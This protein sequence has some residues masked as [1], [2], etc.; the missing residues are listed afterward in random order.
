MNV[1][2]VVQ[3][4]SSPN[5]YGH[6]K[7][8][9]DTAT[10]FD[11][12]FQIGKTTSGRTSFGR[13][14][15]SQS[16]DRLI[17]ATTCL[18]G[19]PVEVQVLDGSVFSGIFHATNAEDFG[20][21]LKMAHTTNDGSWGQKSNSDSHTKPPSRTLII[22]AKDLVQV[23]AKDVPVTRDGFT[24]ELQHENQ[25]ELMT[26]SYISQSRYVEVG[27]ELEHW[28]PDEND[29]GCPELENIFDGPWNRGWDQ[30]E[31]NETLFG[32]KSTFS[33]ELYTTKLERGPQMRELER[34][35][36]RIAREIEGEDTLDFHL[37]EERGI[38]LDGYLEMDEETRFSSV[39][40]GADDSGYDEI[41]DILL[42]SRNNET[43]GGVSGSLTGETCVD[44]STGNA[45]DGTQLS[46][47]SS[48]L[49]EVEYSLTATSR[50]AYHSGSEDQ[51][52]QMLAEQLPKNWFD[53]SQLIGHADTSYP[54]EDEEKQ[55]SCIKI[56]II[57]S[58]D[59]HSFLRQKKESCYK[60]GLSPNATAFDPP[61][62]SSKG[63]EKVSSS[64]ELSEGAA[65]PVT[66]GTKSSLAR[67][68]SSASST[69]DRGGATSTSAG[70]GLS[71][72]S[73]VCSLS[74]E[75]STLNPH[76]KEFKLNPN[77]KSF[78]PSHTPLRPSSPVADGPFYYPAN[79]TAPTHMHAVPVGVGIG[80]S[81]AAQQPVIY[82]PQAASMPQPFYH[83][84]GP[85]Y[86]QQI[87]MGQPR[88]VLYMPTYPPGK[89]RMEAGY[90][91]RTVEEVFRDFKGRRAGLIKALTTD[92]EEF[93]QQC[94]PEKDNLC[95]YGFPSEQWEV[96]LPAE[97][98]PPEL[99]EP[100][101][102]IN[103]ARDGMQEKDWLSLVAVHSDA[104]LLAVA[105]YFGARFGFDKADRKRLF[106]MI[107]DLPT[108]FEV[109]TGAA[110]KQQKEKSS[111]SNHSSNKL[112]SN[113][114][115]RTSE[116]QGKLLKSQP[117][118]EEEGL[119]EEEEE[120]EH[121]ETLCGACGENYA[122]DEFWICCDICEKWFHGKCVKIT[123]ARAEHIKQY[124]CPSCSS[125]KRPRP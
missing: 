55:K 84:N 72:S 97:E 96:N 39:Y 101:L 80:P 30:F 125:N 5:G 105:F 116:T 24:N 42:D 107:N 62:A 89:K 1:Q 85:Q 46:S 50:G 69:S 12:K 92:V 21:V 115:T 43:F 27:R 82:N 68:S 58:A 83:P 3:P 81:I 95:L 60:V 87:I 124:K 90:N 40:R 61:H 66:Q 118:D 100:A 113:S 4:R 93:F 102:G 120:D 29:P 114:K 38:Q 15:E 67:P 49:G 71:P 13:V 108:V 73:S 99:P 37:A 117:K 94:D 109:V 34:E 119:D 8:E 70:R 53:D 54:K 23:I 79:M 16:R 104:W 56:D 20:I 64:N 75:K 47:R 45:Q 18:I 25:Q 106:N 123:P 19:H 22:P 111:V 76:A 41:E 26:D 44:T 91:P 77:A 35:A 52:L 88:P 32:V 10:R 121:G 59:S 11:S 48:L 65:P 98:V 33:E 110:K 36:L 51:A 2:Q 17:Y 74:S 63:Q 86:G 31:A 6:H 57:V 103:F 9:K 78:I 122:S 28:V 112:K 14:I 7:I